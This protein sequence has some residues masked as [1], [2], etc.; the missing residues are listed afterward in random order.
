M[1]G[2]SQMLLDAAFIAQ[3]E[4]LDILSRKIPAGKLGAELTARKIS[5]GAALLPVDYRDYSPGD[6]DRF[7][8]WNVYA[9]LDRL[10]VKLFA[11]EQ[12][13]FVHLLI[14]VSASCDYGIPEKRRYLRQTAAALAYISLSN[15]RHVSLT[16][17][18]RGLVA[19]LSSLR[20]RARISEMLRFLEGLT[21]PKG[22]TPSPSTLGECGGDPNPL[23]EHWASGTDGR[24]TRFFESCAQFAQSRPRPGLCIVLSDFLF[25]EGLKEGLDLL[26]AAGHELICIQALSPQELAPPVTIDRKAMDLIDSE[27]GQELSIAADPSL[28]NQYLVNLARARD[29]IRR[30]VQLHGGQFISVSTDLPIEQL[31]LSNLKAQGI[32]R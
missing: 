7:I 13:S 28:L 16:S 9:R 25:R 26:H 5:R 18:S 11:E 3:L 15:S 10:V 4:R 27:T 6:E 22:V 2:T 12:D 30:A 21:P 14:D 23:P 1:A 29:S 8:D 17:F 19:R 31:F 24:Q 32:L 20:G